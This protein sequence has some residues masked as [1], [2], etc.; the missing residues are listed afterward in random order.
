MTTL[1]PDLQ[2]VVAVDARHHHVEQHRLGR[3][4]GERRDGVAARRG[5]AHREL[6]GERDAEHLAHRR[7]IIDDQDFG[8]GD[9]DGVIGRLAAGIEQDGPCGP[10]LP[11]PLGF[12]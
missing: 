6:L 7:V 4:V 5:I 9:H 11:G 10:V 8:K 12:R 2:H 1:A 3:P